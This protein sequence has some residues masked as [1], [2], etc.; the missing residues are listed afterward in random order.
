MQGMTALHWS[1]INVQFAMAIN[2]ISIQQAAHGC[3]EI[4]IALLLH[5]ADANAEDCSVSLLLHLLYLHRQH[6]ATTRH[7]GL[8][9]LN[10][11]M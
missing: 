7:A 10:S 8:L 5:G 1:V 6:T 9:H 3:V 11:I 2:A 4:V